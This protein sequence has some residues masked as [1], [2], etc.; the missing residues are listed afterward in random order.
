MRWAVAKA[1]LRTTSPP[2]G[3]NVILPSPHTLASIHPAAAPICVYQSSASTCGRASPSALV[4]AFSVRILK[5]EYRYSV[6]S[7]LAIY[8]NAGRREGSASKSCRLLTTWQILAAHCFFSFRGASRC[9]RIQNLC[10]IPNLCSG[11]HAYSRARRRLPPARPC[12]ARPLLCRTQPPR[13]HCCLA[14]ALRRHSP[15]PQVF[16]VRQFDRV[17]WRSV[18]FT[19]RY[20]EAPYP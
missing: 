7:A 5:Q 8:S 19:S 3:T 15:R 16:I 9:L 4:A 14:R 20:S 13:P 6:F 18:F 12:L 17:Q 10:S 11:M 1:L 2:F